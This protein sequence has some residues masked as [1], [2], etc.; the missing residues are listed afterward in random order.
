MLGLYSFSFFST[1]LLDL[2]CHVAADLHQQIADNNSKDGSAQL[3]DF[4]TFSL[5]PS[6]TSAFKLWWETSL[7]CEHL[8]SGGSVH[9]HT[10]THMNAQSHTQF[11]SSGVSGRL[12]P[13][14]RDLRIMSS[15][16]HSHTLL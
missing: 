5:K 10:H 8:I 7:G 11:I 13:V 9:I 1:L 15:L 6:S 4:S 12:K 2:H 3:Y 16:F 14:G